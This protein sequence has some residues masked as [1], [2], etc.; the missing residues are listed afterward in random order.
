M[1]DSYIRVYGFEVGCGAENQITHTVGSLPGVVSTSWYAP[2]HGLC[3]SGTS[4]DGISSVVAALRRLGYVVS[5]ND[6][7]ACCASS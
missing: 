4:D 6:P 2:G 1:R 7:C 3:V 5:A